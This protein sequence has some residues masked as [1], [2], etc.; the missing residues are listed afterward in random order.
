M[1]RSGGPVELVYKW[2][3][4]W[5]GAPPEAAAGPRC[6]ADGEKGAALDSDEAPVERALQQLSQGSDVHSRWG[7]TAGEGQCFAIVPSQAQPRYLLPV[8]NPRCIVKGLSMATPSVRWGRILSS[9][10]AGLVNAGWNGWGREKIVIPEGRLAPLTR[11]IREITGEAAPVFAAFL[12]RPGRYRKLTVQAMSRQGEVLGFLKLPLTGM[13]NERI[14]HE[15]EVLDKLRALEG[16]IPRVLHAGRWRE[17][18]VVFQSPC[19]GKPGPTRFGASQRQFL[20]RLWEIDGIEKSGQALVAEVRARWEQAAP[21]LTAEEKRL[22]QVA[23]ERQAARLSGVPVRCGWMHGDF[24]ASNTVLKPNGE[25]FVVDWEL[26]EFG[27]PILWDIFNFQAVRGAIQREK[28]FPHSLAEDG[29]A[30]RETR[31]GL[32]ALFL[33]DSLVLLAQEGRAGREKAMDCRC[34]WLARMG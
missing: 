4:R 5:E 8:G 23:L 30:D 20:R 2:L 21:Y 25:L 31:K 18:Y 9:L 16:H 22:G 24:V 11:L 7:G 1:R 32:A 14:R 10:L 13:A 29:S 33:V 12:G 15:T 6:G 34:R 26:A 3:V 28:E 27:R 19:S 17:D